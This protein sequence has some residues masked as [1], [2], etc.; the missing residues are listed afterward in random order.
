MIE[1]IPK[2][3]RFKDQGSMPITL[4]T[5]KKRQDLHYGVCVR[6]NVVD[7][8]HCHGNRCEK[9]ISYDHSSIYVVVDHYHES[10]KISK[11]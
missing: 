4:K 2:E 9:N 11:A 8:N 6:D 7:D 3:A 5:E 1:N 10:E